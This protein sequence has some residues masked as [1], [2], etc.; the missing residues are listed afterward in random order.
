MS[1]E[2]LKTENKFKTFFIE[3]KKYTKLIVSLLVIIL[4]ILMIIL[5]LNHR[6]QKQNIIISEKFNKANVLIINKNDLEAKNIL[7]DIVNK[8]NKF[9]SPLSL[10]L[11]L[12]EELVKDDKE[13]KELFNKVSSIKKIE[14]ENLN[15]IKI[16]KA[17][18]LFENGNEEEIL[19][20]LNP[21]INSESLWRRDAI[22]LLSEYF[23]Y[24]GNKSKSEEYKNLLNSTKN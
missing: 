7:I 14:R 3:S 18:F 2:D 12:E 8:K 5:F 24:K 21:I 1:S 11:I 6:S 20:V 23:L 17:L 16:K 19:S 13:M 4:V 15:L 22:K 9:Y 10:F